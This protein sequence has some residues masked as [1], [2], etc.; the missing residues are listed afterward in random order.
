M[1]YSAKAERET[2]NTYSVTCFE[3][4][5]A[6]ILNFKCPVKK[7]HKIALSI[8]YLPYSAFGESDPVYAT[9]HLEI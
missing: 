8:T 9:F 3:I 7:F 1:G 2:V 4:P 6:L 5:T